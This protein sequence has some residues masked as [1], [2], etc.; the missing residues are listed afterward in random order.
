MGEE[1][2][3]GPVKPTA[4]E[5]ELQSIAGYF[6][7]AAL[8]AKI[9]FS[10]L[11]KWDGN[12]YLWPVTCPWVNEHTGQIDS[13]SVVI[14]HLSGALDFACPHTH[15]HDRTWPKDFRPKLEELV[16]RPLRFGESKT[17]LT[18]N[19][20][21]LEEAAVSVKSETA[22]VPP[23]QTGLDESPMK[24]LS[25]ED[26]RFPSECLEGDRLCDLTHELTDGTFIPPQFVHGDLQVWAGH[27][28]D[29]HIVPPNSTY[30]NFTTRFYLNKFSFHPQ[31]GKG[32]SWERVKWAFSDLLI[33]RPKEGIV[34]PNRIYSPMLVDGTGWGSGPFAVSQL[35]DTP[36]CICFLDEGSVMWLTKGPT[37]Q[38]SL[39][40]VFLSL[41]EGSQ[42]STGSFK[43]K[44][45]QA[46]NVHLSQTACF[47]WTPL[48]RVIKAV[49]RAGAVICHECVYHLAQRSH[50]TGKL[51]RCC[52]TPARKSTPL[53]SATE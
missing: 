33:P 37:D 46:T 8:Q 47:T 11:R 17:R 23:L 31:T 18:Q 3:A 52:R 9:K 5:E 12:G 21:P 42:H 49:G 14:L 27:C 22:L 1:K 6:E 25:E 20:I 24:V 16:G 51:G 36:N 10:P 13:G 50:W 15:C 44:K 39:E 29:G 53:K 45:Y 38:K 35:V 26:Y 48:P 7:E 34:E 40:N 41:F 30:L 43:N 28:M 2:G 32:E 19:G 4:D